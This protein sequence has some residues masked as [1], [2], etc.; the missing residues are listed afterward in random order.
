MMV[1]SEIVVFSLI[2]K[3][4]NPIIRGLCPDSVPVLF[5]FNPVNLIER[6]RTNKQKKQVKTSKLVGFYVWN[7]TWKSGLYQDL[8]WEGEDM[9]SRSLYTLDREKTVPSQSED[10]REC[11]VYPARIWLY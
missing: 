9:I 10:F 7:S 3:A 6:K 2:H 1:L 8:A 5:E 11:G 4:Y